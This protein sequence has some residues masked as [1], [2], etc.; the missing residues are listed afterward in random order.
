MTTKADL[1]NE[2]FDMETKR[3]LS[4]K[5]LNDANAAIRQLKSEVS[6]KEANT[7]HQLRNV[8]ELE[9][10]LRGIKYVLESF[11]NLSRYDFKGVNED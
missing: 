10:Q 5:T 4:R 9:G 7:I 2:L 1:Q 11:S 8:S 3:D 6:S